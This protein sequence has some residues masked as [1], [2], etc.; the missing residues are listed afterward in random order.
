MNAKKNLEK[1]ARES[2][3]KAAEAVRLATEALNEANAAL[4]LISE[5][6]EDQLDQVSGGTDPLGGVPRVPENPI[7]EDLR[8]KGLLG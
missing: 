6:S 2:V 7:E 1:K 8:K 4:K 5:L 3:A